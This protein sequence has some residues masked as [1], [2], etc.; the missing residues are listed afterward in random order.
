MQEITYPGLSACALYKL[1]EEQKC[2]FQ[3]ESKSV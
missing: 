1:F 2:V 3:I